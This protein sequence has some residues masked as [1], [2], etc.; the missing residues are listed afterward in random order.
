MQILARELAMQIDSN[1]LIPNAGEPGINQRRDNQ[2]AV[3]AEQSEGD[4]KLR[5]EYHNVLRR[6]I[7]SDFAGLESLE[8]VRAELE[9]GDLDEP[10]AIRTAARNIATFGI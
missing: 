8:Q 3:K 1:N 4:L 7:E 9:S 2:P 5:S 10:A 6:A